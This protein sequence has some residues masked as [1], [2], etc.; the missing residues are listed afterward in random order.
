MARY[1][2]LAGS[3]TVLILT[4]S[5]AAAQT[6]QVSV[7]D[8]GWQTRPS[9]YEC[10]TRG[11]KV[12]HRQIGLDNGIVNYALQYTGCSDP[13]HNG[14]H[15]CSEGN[16]GMPLPSP[17]NFY[18]CGFLRVLVNG[19]DATKYQ[20]TD[21]QVVDRGGRGEMQIT[22]SAPAADVSLRLALLPGSNHLAG[23][24]KWRTHEGVKLETVQLQTTCY[25]SFFTNK[26]VGERHVMTPRT[27]LAQ[28]QTLALQPA[29]DTW[30]YYYDK[31]FDKALGEGA[32]PCAMVLDPAG[33]A[34]GKVMVTGYPVQTQV[35]YQPAAGQAR[36]AFYDFTGKTNAEA[37]AYLKTQGAADLA[38]L[39]ALDFRPLTVQQTDL[40]AMA[41][42]AK[43][44]LT[45]AADDGV[46]AQPQVD[47][48]LARTT[49]LQA[50]SQAGDWKAEADLSNA[51]SGAANLFWRL[52]IFALLNR[53]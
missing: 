7:S 1:S 41:A 6:A 48:L 26:R 11:H 47:K 46:S 33:V 39:Q 28:P 50:R 49:E 37:E 2:W 4:G 14:E 53:S 43:Q 30:L 40:A 34:G 23:L 44:L 32:G 20:V 13:A 38:K 36:V 25:P 8:P 24:L 42:E 17:C 45:D 9:T 3:L 10:G 31:V 18:W 19:Q 27:D 35:D 15:P 52:K 51:I 22:W 16:F 29:Q 12:E 21:M 5:L